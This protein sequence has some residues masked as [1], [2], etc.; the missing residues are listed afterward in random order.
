MPTSQS[1]PRGLTRCPG[2]ERRYTPAAAQLNQFRTTAL[3]DAGFAL[4][5]SA[6]TCDP[7]QRVS[8]AAALEHSWFLAEPL[9]APLSRVEIRQ[10][11]RNRDEAISSGAH[12]LAIAQQRAQQNAS[13]IAASIRG[14]SAGAAV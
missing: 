14:A 3:S 5:N 1:A 11:R 4:L 7:S 13:A 12:Q 6:L 2:R 9:P 10:L 8:A